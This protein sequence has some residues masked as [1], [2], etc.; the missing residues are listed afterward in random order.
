MQLLFEDAANRL[1]LLPFLGLEVGTARV[2]PGAPPLAFPVGLALIEP[3]ERLHGPLPDVRIAD[4]SELRDQ[5][6][7]HA[8]IVDRLEDA[9]GA[10][11]Q[12]RGG[13][14]ERRETRVDRP[15]G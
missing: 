2:G 6:V 9:G 12:V 7:D 14:V 1:A 8:W 5:A 13:W 11:D 15:Q 3:A 4:M 10:L